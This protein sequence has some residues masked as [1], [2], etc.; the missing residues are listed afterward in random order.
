[1]FKSIRQRISPQSERKVIKI[2]SASSFINCLPEEVLSDPHT[3]HELLVC[4]CVDGDSFRT[5]QRLT[6][7]HRDYH[8][9]L[10]VQEQAR[11]LTAYCANMHPELLVIKYL[12]QKSPEALKTTDEFGGLPL[13]YISFKGCNDLSIIQYLVEQYPEALRR[14]TTEG[15][16]AR[17]LALLAGNISIAKFLTEAEQKYYPE[18]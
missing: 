4:A 3:L 2:P 14:K 8:E 9:T 15:K 17:E 18:K 12:L 6:E 10:S 16:T 1:M 7:A 5:I 11:P 13:H